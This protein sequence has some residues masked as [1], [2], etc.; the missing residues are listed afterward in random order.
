[1][2][3]TEKS[4]CSCER[5]TDKRT[6]KEESRKWKARKRQTER[7]NENVKN[8][9]SWIKW[10]RVAVVARKRQKHRSKRKEKGMK[11]K[12]KKKQIYR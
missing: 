1:M 8:D 10:R 4:R 3:Q 6:H 5:N 9:C 11:E 2:E 12:G 7:Q